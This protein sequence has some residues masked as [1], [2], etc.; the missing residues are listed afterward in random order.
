M[1]GYTAALKD[2]C[3][4]FHFS[5]WRPSSILDFFKVRIFNIW[6]VSEGQFALSCQI[7]C[8]SVKPLWRYSLFEFSR[9]RPSTIFD[10]LY[11]CLDHPRR[12]FGGLC[13]CAKFGWNQWSSFRIRSFVLC[14]QGSSLLRPFWIGPLHQPRDRR[15]VNRCVWYCGVRAM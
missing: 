14:S 5:W 12:A 11:N 1:C 3:T 9:W 15:R 8:H 13:H 4:C 7:S 10:Y 6:Y 2:G